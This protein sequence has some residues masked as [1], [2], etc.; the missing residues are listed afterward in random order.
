LESRDGDDPEHQV[1]HNLGQGLKRPNAR[2][3]SADDSQI[4]RCNYQSGNRSFHQSISARCH[5][6]NG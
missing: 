5:S 2:E 6:R 4:E 3:A 1:I